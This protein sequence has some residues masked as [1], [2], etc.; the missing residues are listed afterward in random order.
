MLLKGTITVQSP[1]KKRHNSPSRATGRVPSLGQE[2]EDRSMGSTLAS[3]LIGVSAK[4]KKKK[5]KKS[6]GKIS[7]LRLARWKIFNGLWAVG[8]VSSCLVTG[9]GMIKAEVSKGYTSQVAEI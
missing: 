8:V 2:A 6:Q 5:K 1:R 7:G 3:I 4:K 9:P